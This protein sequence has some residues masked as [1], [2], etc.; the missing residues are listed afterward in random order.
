MVDFATNCLNDERLIVA[1]GPS[2]GRHYDM[3]IPSYLVT[4]AGTR[5]SFERIA[6]E[7]TDG[8]VALAQLA[9]N[10]CVI[11]PGLIYREVQSQ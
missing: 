7:G 1:F 10:E 8:L 6:Q 11:A 3:D 5:L 4:A 9:P 2:C